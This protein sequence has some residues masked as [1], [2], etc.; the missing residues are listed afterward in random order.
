M[1]VILSEQLKLILNLFQMT[2]IQI[3]VA[4]CD[5]FTSFIQL[6]PFLWK[7][8]NPKQKSR[9]SKK[10]SVEVRLQA[11]LSPEAQMMS[12]ESGF[13]PTLISVPINMAS[14]SSSVMAIWRSSSTR[15]IFCKD[16][17]DSKVCALPQHTRKFVIVFFWPRSVHRSTPN[18]SCRPGKTPHPPD[19]GIHSTQNTWN[20]N[21][22]SDSFLDKNNS[23]SRHHPCF[24]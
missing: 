9:V 1:S 14:F 8:Q 24:K 2:P 10:A 7:W 15:V 23:C 21:R 20:K 6:G 11:C 12:P 19:W 18:K 3:T 16:Q 22:G 5:L 17:S 4:I 13:S